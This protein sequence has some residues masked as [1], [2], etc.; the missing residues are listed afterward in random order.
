MRVKDLKQILEQ[1]NEDMLVCFTRYGAHHMI[2]NHV[3]SGNM[4]EFSGMDLQPLLK[5]M[6]LFLE[7]EDSGV[8][9]KYCED[10]YLKQKISKPLIIYCLQ[11]LAQWHTTD[12]SHKEESIVDVLNALY[13]YSTAHYKFPF[14]C[15][16]C[17][18]TEQELNQ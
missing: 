18:L 14:Y 5:N 6:E 12:D 16:P 8:L 11:T 2:L 9:L 1:Y 15:V 13:D 7:Q 10:L 3:S 17:F 4:I